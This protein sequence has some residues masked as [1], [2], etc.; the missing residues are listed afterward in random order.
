[1]REFKKFLKILNL[2]SL[3][4]M[5][6]FVT[7]PLASNAECCLKQLVRFTMSDKTLSCDEDFDGNVEGSSLG[8]ILYPNND[9]FLDKIGK[10]KCEIKLCG[11]GKP[12]VEGIYCGK[13]PC[14]LFGCNCEGGCIQG[15]TLQNFRAIHG[16][17]VYNVHYPR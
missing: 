12:V 6:I 5:A 10:G 14:N 1:M 8:E 4:F 9:I 15:N 16:K 7:F 17:N 13:G 3:L 11:D 2:S